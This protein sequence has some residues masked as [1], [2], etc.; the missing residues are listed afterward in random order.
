MRSKEKKWTELKL[1]GLHMYVFYLLENLLRRQVKRNIRKV[2]TKAEGKEI[3][4]D[5]VGT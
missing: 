2:C 1:P 4:S 5:L 3:A